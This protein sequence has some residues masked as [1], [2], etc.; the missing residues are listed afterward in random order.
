MA[1]AGQIVS[2]AE[3]GSR[4]IQQK[5]DAEEIKAHYAEYGWN[6]MEIIAKGDTL[7][8]KINGVVF[9]TVTDRDRKMS[10]K[11]GFIALQDHGKGC[12]VAFRNLRIQEFPKP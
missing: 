4:T 11:K 1:T 9:S 10:R 5:E 6:A 8:Q 12:L 2:L 3:D 7:I